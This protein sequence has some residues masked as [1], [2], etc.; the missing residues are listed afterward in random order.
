MFLD[1]ILH[2]GI[3]AQVKKNMQRPFTLL[4][5]QLQSKTEYNMPS[6]HSRP[7]GMVLFLHKTYIFFHTSVLYGVNGSERTMIA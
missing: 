4:H 1:A 7:P 3:G 5:M 2:F 6:C